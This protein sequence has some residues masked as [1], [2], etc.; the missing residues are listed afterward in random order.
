L[1]RCA[2]RGRCRLP[3]PRAPPLRHLLPLFLWYH[4]LLPPRYTS[5][6]CGL[7]GLYHAR[8]LNARAISCGTASYQHGAACAHA[9]RRRVPAHCCCH[10]EYTACRGEL[11]SSIVRAALSF[12]W[13]SQVTVRTPVSAPLL[14]RISLQFNRVLRVCSLPALCLLLPLLAW[15]LTII[16]RMVVVR[17]VL[18]YAGS[19][20]AHN[21]NGRILAA[22]STW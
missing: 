15:T 10:T 22:I 16:A 9:S 11:L 19:F 13:G 12:A 2:C 6:P 1:Q 18:L 7:T 4:R 20:S 3:H 21:N 14:C 17:F 5:W 8:G